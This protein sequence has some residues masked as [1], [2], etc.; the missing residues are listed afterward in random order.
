[1]TKKVFITGQI[2][3]NGV[4]LLEKHFKVSVYRG[5][6][7]ITRGELLKRVKGA[8]AILSILTEKIDEKVFESAGRELKIVANYAVGFDNID[9]QAAKK[10]SVVVTN[11]PGVLSD[12]VA[13]HTLALIMAVAKRVVESDQFVRAGKFKS[14][15]PMGFLG[16]G[17]KNK[18]LGILGLGRIGSIVGHIAGRG[19]SMKILYHDVRR[20]NQFEREEKAEFLSFEGLLKRADVLTI[21]VPLLPT[22]KHLINAKTLRLMKPTAI[23][24]NTSRGPVI[25][26]RALVLA[27]KEKR[28]FGAGLDVFEL[29]PKL[30]PDLKGLKNVVLTPH[31]ASATEEAREAM[32]EIAAKNIIAVLSGQKPP[33]PIHQ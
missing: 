22:T 2:P 1:M 24:I 27:L 6:G 21:H 30:S 15:M 8:F 3:L 10:R 29:E 5:K 11:T 28:I 23:V 9:L 26:E 19:F 32:S 7:P 14:W 25:D 18:A 17:L 4:R 16:A 12:S 13:E 20:N 31:I 33:N